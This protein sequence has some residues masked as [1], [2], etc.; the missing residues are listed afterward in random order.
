VAIDATQYERSQVMRQFSSGAIERE[1]N[2]AYVGFLGARDG[3]LDGEP[4]GARD[5]A[6][7]GEP[8]GAVAAAPLPPIVTGNWGCGAFGG[9][10]QLKAMIQWMAASLAGRVCICAAPGC[11]IAGCRARLK[12]SRRGALPNRKC[13]TCGVAEEAAE[14]RFQLR[15]LVDSP[16]VD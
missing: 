14:G 15:D 16:S 2:K 12:R 1:L 3:A 7:D 6:L 11:A 9:D 10:L 8:S 4:I 13:A 5:G